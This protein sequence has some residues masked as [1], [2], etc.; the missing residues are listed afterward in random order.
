VRSKP[1]AE[2]CSWLRLETNQ[3]AFLKFSNSWSLSLGD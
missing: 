3:E 2:A 1:G